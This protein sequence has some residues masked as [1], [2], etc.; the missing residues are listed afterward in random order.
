MGVAFTDPK[1]KEGPIYPAVS[2]LHSAGCK[3]RYGVPVPACF[4]NW[5]FKLNLE[6]MLKFQI[7]RLK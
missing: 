6:S 7:V 2:L 3:I 4:L 5:D 1:L